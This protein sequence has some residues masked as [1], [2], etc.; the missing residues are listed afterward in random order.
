MANTGTP[1]PITTKPRILVEFFLEM[2][3]HNNELTMTSTH[4]VDDGNP[5]GTTRSILGQESPLYQENRQ[6]SSPL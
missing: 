1:W 5:E 3:I 4:F 6:K 2:G